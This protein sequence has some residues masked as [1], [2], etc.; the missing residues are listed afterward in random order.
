M[1]CKLKWGLLRPIGK[2]W[3]PQNPILK[4]TQHP[5][6]DNQFTLHD[7]IKLN[8]EINLLNSI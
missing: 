6:I 7:P 5:T 2:Y 1:K 8:W 4:M 3:L